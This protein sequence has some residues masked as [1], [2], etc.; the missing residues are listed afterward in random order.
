M[1]ENSHYFYIS[2]TCNDEGCIRQHLNFLGQN[3]S[4]W[5]GGPPIGD[6][7]NISLPIVFSDGYAT[8]GYFNDRYAARI[9]DLFHFDEDSPGCCAARAEPDESVLHIRNFLVEMPRKGKRQGY[10]ELSPDKVAHELFGHLQAGDKVAFTSRVSGEFVSNYAAALKARGLHVRIIEGQNPTQDFCFLMS[11]R[12]EFAGF[13]MS[14]YSVWAAYLGNAT[15]S[16]LYSVKSPDRIASLGEDGYFVRQN[17]TDLSMK[18]RVI[19]EV[20]NSEE[21]DAVEKQPAT[22]L[23]KIVSRT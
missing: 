21:Q 14:S 13:A 16:R 7:Y 15:I 9:A 23:E 1:Q 4:D 12:K 3:M 18:K 2:P 22:D 20:Y 19:F 6:H 17:W 10:E 8:V 11:A 5:D